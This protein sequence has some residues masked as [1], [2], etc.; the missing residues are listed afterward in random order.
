MGYGQYPA[1]GQ[2]TPYGMPP[3][4]QPCPHWNG[5]TCDFVYKTGGRCK[6]EAAHFP[7][8]NTFQRP[9]TPMAPRK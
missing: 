5:H 1:Y 9:F 4:P 6:F 7:L 8:Q 3:P 2:H